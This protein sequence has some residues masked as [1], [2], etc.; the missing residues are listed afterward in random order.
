MFI[1]LIIYNYSQTQ[2]ETT[3]NCSLFK[4]QVK[5]FP[6]LRF[7]MQ[8]WRVIISSFFH[9]NFAHFFLNLFGL[10]IYGYFVEWYYG[11]LRYSI[12]LLCAIIYSH[13]FSSIIQKST[14]S[15]TPS[16]VLFAILILKCFFLWEYRAYRRLLERKNFLYILLALIGG[17][18]LIPIFVVNNVDYSASIGINII[19]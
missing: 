10:Q 16:S 4:L 19:N 2:S 5:Y 18:N 3:W 6:K 11:K 15:T 13:F 1:F 12:T 9:S 17:L 8:L 14:I 7:N